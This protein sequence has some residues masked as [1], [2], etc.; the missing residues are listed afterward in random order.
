ME[1]VTDSKQNRKYLAKDSALTSYNIREQGATTVTPFMRDKCRTASF[2]S[3][4]AG[5]PRRIVKT[6]IRAR[7]RSRAT[8]TLN[9]VL[10]IKCVIFSF[11]AESEPM[12]FLVD[13]S[14]SKFYI[15]ANHD[16]L[17]IDVAASFFFSDQFYAVIH[18]D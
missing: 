10:I 6:Q 2:G 4:G 1:K 9:L 3:T 16:N 14:L 13:S 12:P 7:F 18:F 15:F 5:V 11:S 8:M 17:L